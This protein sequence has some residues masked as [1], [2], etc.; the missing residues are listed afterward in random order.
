MRTCLLGLALCLAAAPAF[1]QGAKE[2]FTVSFNAGYQAAT[3]SFSDRLTFEVYKEQG[4]TEAQ[5]PVKGNV[6]FDVGGS[7]RLWKRLGA[8]VMVSRHT[9][10]HT[11]HTVSRVPHPL[12]LEHLRD[13]VGDAGGITRTET[14]A[15][16]QVRFLVP[17]PGHLQFALSAGPSYI[18]VEQDLITMVRYQ[19]AYPF[20]DAPFTGADTKKA[21]R[22]AAGYNAGADAT[23]MFNRTFGAGAE[24]RFAR[25]RVKL[26]A[27]GDRTLSVDAGGTQAGVGVRIHF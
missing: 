21:R 17:T 14:G 26:H 3:N 25:A 1:A 8:G 5:Y 20:D 18:S 6:M 13:V 23:W 2:R 10:D 7:I 11:V 12:Y 19:D 16:V 22:S 4:T 9:R 27:P 24:V 15:H